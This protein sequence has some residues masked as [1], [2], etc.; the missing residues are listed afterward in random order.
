[1]RLVLGMTL[2]IF[3]L[4]CANQSPQTQTSNRVNVQAPTQHAKGVVTLEEADFKKEVDDPEKVIEQLLT[5]N[6]MIFV[7]LPDSPLFCR[8][9]APLGSHIKTV[10][11]RTPE[12]LAKERQASDELKREWGRLERMGVLSSG[13]GL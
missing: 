4:G 5:S 13:V 8:K 7:N 6:E 9:E 10:I 12:Q 3:L 2:S 1:M 11:C